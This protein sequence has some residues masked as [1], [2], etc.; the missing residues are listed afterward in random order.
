MSHRGLHHVTIIA[1]SAPRNLAF[2]TGVLGLRLVK[3]TVN[4]DDPRTYHFYYGDETGQPG[5]IVTFFPW[6]GVAPGRLGVGETQETV[7]R[8]PEASLGYWTQRLIEKGVTHDAVAKR[9]G[10]SVLS[11]KDPDGTRLAFAALRGVESETGSGAGDVPAEHAIRGLHGV[12]LLLEK[13]EATAA[14]LTDVLG[15]VAGPSEGTTR[16]YRV[17]DAKLGAVVDLREVGGFPRG[18]QGAGSVHHVA[19]RAADD[20]DQAEMA[21]KLVDRHRLHATE[22]KDRQYFHS[23][24]FREPGRVLFEIATDPP[25]F[26]LDEPAQSLGQALM[27]PQFLEDQRSEIEAA[28][29]R[30]DLSASGTSFASADLSFRHVFERGSGAPPPVLLLHG[31]GG[32]ESDLLP[33]GR[34]IAPGA[35]LLAPRGKVLENGMPR[36]FRRLSEG[37]FDEDDLRFRVGELSDFIGEARQ[38]YGLDAAPIAVGFSNGANIAAALLLLHPDALAGAV[39]I[40]P[41]TPLAAEDGEPLAGK[42]ILILTGSADQIAPPDRAARLAAMLTARGAEVHHEVIAAGHG[43]SPQDIKQA[44]AFF[45]TLRERSGAPT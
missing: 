6:E 16:R 24:Y 15:F 35:S 30:L 1:G 5:T 32:D 38:A 22:R 40:R 4:F 39:L 19:F 43:V 11:F 9:F 29:P 26:A 34:T 44:A 41:M 27:L 20:A 17:P 14:I 28:L 33:L 12:S 3:K 13:A 45:K 31:T 21:R 37:V 42:P 25:G 36:F 18:R 10:E 8:I 7:F 23:V 2:Y